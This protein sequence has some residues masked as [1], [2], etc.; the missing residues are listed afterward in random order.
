MNVKSPSKFRSPDT[1][2]ILYNRT[3]MEYVIHRRTSDRAE[4]GPV[5]DEVC[6]AQ[7]LT[8]EGTETAPIVLFLFP[9]YLGKRAGHLLI[10]GHKSE[11]MCFP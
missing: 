8:T 2:V 5:A 7:D 10:C 1:M 3:E 6:N 4:F 9:R 11:L